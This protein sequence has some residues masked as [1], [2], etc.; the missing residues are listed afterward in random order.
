MPVGGDLLIPLGGSTLN[1]PA[2]GRPALQVAVY[3]AVYDAPM[4][5]TNIYLTETEQAALDARAAA[6]GTTRSEIVRAI[7]DR[8]LNLCADEETDLDE[9]LAAAAAELGGRSRVL[10]RDDPDLSIS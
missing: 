5:R 4:R 10:S 6:A 9:T 2:W 3:V 1:R 8:E 7:V